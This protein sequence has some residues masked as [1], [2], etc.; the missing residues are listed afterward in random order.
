MSKLFVEA[1]IIVLTE[2][3]SPFTA[4]RQN[5]RKITG[6]DFYEIFCDCNLEICEERDVKGLYKKAREGKIPFFTGIDSPYEI[7][8]A[9]EL[10]IKTESDLSLGVEKVFEFIKNEV[11]I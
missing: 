1:G 2:F 3:I 6:S 5:A 4:D 7:P 9:P 11:E 8:S 10:I